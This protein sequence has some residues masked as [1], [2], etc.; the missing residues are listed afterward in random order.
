VTESRPAAEVARLRR[1]YDGYEAAG[2]MYGLWAPEH[3]G[4]RAMRDE[5]D[6]L[7]GR[8]LART[9]DRAPD[10][11]SDRIWHAPLAR[12]RILDLG[13]GDG[14][15]LASLGRLGAEPARSLG[16]DVRFATL[17]AAHARH[18]RLGFACADGARLPI[19]DGGV[20]CVLAFTVFSSILDDPV[21]RAVAAEI[22]RVLRPGGALVWYDFRIGN[23]CNPHVRGVSRR[24]LAALFPGW[25]RQLRRV[26]LVPPLA[27]RL[28]AATPWLYPVL[29]A[30]PPLRTH[31][32]GVLERPA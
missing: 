2:R 11:A 26:T 24:A 32:L 10:R 31:W 23:P 16:A 25:R 30:L 3:P 7:L 28:G 21:A 8:L 29:A 4:N 5:R 20:D 18:P 19:R 17:A 9:V 27:R 1:V 22:A 12:R 14:A 6:R 15:V 13:C